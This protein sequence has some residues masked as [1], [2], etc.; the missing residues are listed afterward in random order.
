MDDFTIDANGDAWCTM[1]LVQSNA[2]TNIAGMAH[3]GSVAQ[4]KNYYI[5]ASNAPSQ[6][7]YTQ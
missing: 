7:F 2:H 3:S 5:N 1:Q 4:W 6:L